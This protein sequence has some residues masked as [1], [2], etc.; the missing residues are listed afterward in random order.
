MAMELTPRERVLRRV[1]ALELQRTSW[2]AHWK[3]INRLLLPRSGAFNPS[4]NPNQG[5]EKN[6]ILDNSGTRAL[7]TLSA[8]MHSGMTSP[9]R[10]WLKLETTDTDLMNVKAVSRW[11]DIVTQKMLTIFA[12]SNTY[13]VLHDL[14]EE[15]GAYAT[16]LAFVLPDYE[17]VIHL[18][19]LTVGEYAL[20]MDEKGRV[21]AVARRYMMTVEQI[22]RRWVLKR[23][24]PEGAQEFDWSNVSPSLKNAWDRCDYD[25]YVAIQQ[26]VQP[27]SNREYGRLDAKNMPFESTYIEEGANGEKVLHE[28]GFR[29]FPA[30]VPR[31]QVKGQS[32]YGTNC[33]GMVAL[34]DLRTLQHQ[35]LRKGQAIDY[36]S[37]PPVQIPISLANSPTDLLPGGS[38]FVD[39][40][41]PNNAIKTAFDV[42]LDIRA[43]LEDTQDVRRRVDAAFYA[44]LFLFLSNIQGLT[45]QK[46]AREVAEIHEEKLLML[47]P[48]VEGMEGELRVLADIAFDAGMEAGIFPPP[49]REIQNQE[50]KTEFIGLLSQAQ[51]SVS[52]ASID[53]WVG[54]IASIATAKNDPSVWDKAD[55]DQ[56]ADRAADYLGVAPEVVRGDDEVL[57]IRQARQQLMQQ[58]QQM[59]QAERAAATAKTLAGA[60]TGGDN[61]LTNVARGFAQAA[62]A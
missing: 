55:T 5:G 3:E 40:S 52:M 18:Y 15:V 26:V 37:N 32:I 42:Q 22:V 9:A 1:A 14:Y 62:N 50:L 60:D 61:A 44:D 21:N 35:Q 49:P 58:E 31:W 20:G 4:T 10:A 6:D 59:Q 25:T 57:A 8:G 2:M 11:C 34:G 13:R 46:T 39:M 33:P 12:R 47:G 19:P 7:G 29:R 28:S 36:Q 56:I 48:V 30:I 43:L 41:G 45:G 24:G 51:R 17:N 54:A 53:R 38:T 16:S 23:R 27:R